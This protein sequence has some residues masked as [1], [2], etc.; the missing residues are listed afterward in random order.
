LKMPA[1]TE[2]PGGKGGRV[3][4]RN[5][6]QD[7]RRKETREA[8]LEAANEV[9]SSTPYVRATID[10][11]IRAANISRA[12]F[13]GH[14]ESKLE[15]ALALYESIVPDWMEIF[16]RLADMPG[17]DVTHLKA[18]FND[19]AKVYVDHGYIT[20]LVIQLA[21]FEQVF[22][23]R[24]FEDRDKLIDRLAS[25]GVGGFVLTSRDNSQREENR[26]RAHLILRTMDLLCSDIA[27]FGRAPPLIDSSIDLVTSDLS[28]FLQ[29]G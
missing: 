27:M 19:L 8:I 29:Q 5:A 1:R 20:T 15:L 4:G 11:I 23:E 18:W 10:E 3:G 24:L 7:K 16:D 14:F 12:T 13:Y 25:K 6:F 28:V 22:R 9:F 26:A 21:V 17:D 2:A